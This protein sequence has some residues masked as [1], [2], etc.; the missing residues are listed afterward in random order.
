MLVDQRQRT[1]SEGAAVQTGVGQKLAEL[2]ERNLLGY[3]VVAMFL[4]GKTFGDDEMVIA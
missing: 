3:D 1:M 4:D 2:A